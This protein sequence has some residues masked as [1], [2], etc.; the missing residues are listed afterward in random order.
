MRRYVVMECTVFED[1]RD[2]RNWMFAD[3][4][5]FETFNDAKEWVTVNC[6]DLG[7]TWVNESF[8]QT[9]QRC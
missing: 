7:G 1:R 8:I 9:L 4:R 2:I 6:R 5:T 3:E